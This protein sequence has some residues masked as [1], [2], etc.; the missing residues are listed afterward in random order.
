M[1]A[2]RETLAL[3]AKWS[4]PRRTSEDTVSDILN[5]RF[6]AMPSLSADTDPLVNRLFAP[7]SLLLP[8]LDRR[9]R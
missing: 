1:N 3:A 7:E 8:P 5:L 4:I 6:A 2:D 9:P